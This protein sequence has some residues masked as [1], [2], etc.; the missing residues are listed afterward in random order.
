MNRRVQCAEGIHDGSTALPL[1][2]LVDTHGSITVAACEA[3]DKLR[4][5][6]PY[7]TTSVKSKSHL[8]TIYSAALISPL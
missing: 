1:V 7:L 3:V 6:R 8:T 4:L 2:Y 5:L